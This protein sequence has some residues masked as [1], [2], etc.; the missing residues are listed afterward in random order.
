MS[1]VWPF[2]PVVDTS[3]LERIEWLTDVLPS[4][5]GKEQRVRVRGA[6]RRGYEFQ[7]AAADDG[8][9][10]RMENF[11]IAHH[12]EPM[13]LPVWPDADQ[14]AAPLAAGA[15]A[16][17]LD[18]ADKDYAV[19]GQA[20]VSDGLAAEAV[21]ISAVDAASLT[22]SAL[23]SAWP[24]HSFVAPACA[25]RLADRLTSSNPWPAVLRATVR[26]QGETGWDYL[27]S[28]YG[29]SYGKYY[30][31]T[32][33]AAAYRGYPVKLDSTQWAF[34]GNTEFRRQLGVFDP[35]VGNRAVFDPT[36]VEA[37][38]RQY[39][40]ALP[41]RA[42]IAAFRAWL[43]ARAGR[44]TPLWVASAQRDLSVAASIGSADTAIT[45]DNV[46]YAGLGAV[47]IG[48]RDIV[49]ETVAGATYYRRITAASAIDAATESLVIDSAL[50]VTLAP[51]DIRS[52]SF[53]R[54]CRLNADAVE[55]A[56]RWSG[57]AE[58]R[59]A[60]DSLRDDA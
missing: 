31:A 27:A 48:R 44:L 37:T 35:L 52:V 51:A 21:T 18:T 15:T 41:S 29:R 54:L 12:A 20:I 4:R 10:V 1:A 36:G 34:D 7:V 46:G 38:S 24:A 25:A 19:G 57:A 6:P 22:V 43:F 3:I 33:E 11:L 47:P 9:R 23:A 39:R 28:G 5:N 26:F 8:A 53:L 13:L 32:T 59:L 17:P 40:V 56:H 55:I 14:L 45:I 60:F 16:I 30:G 50:G 58:S 42:D 49:I 2:A